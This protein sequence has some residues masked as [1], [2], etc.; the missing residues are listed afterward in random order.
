MPIELI[1]LNS[2][3]EGEIKKL[4]LLMGPA[5]HIGELSNQYREELQLLY[6]L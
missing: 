2:L 5:T 3:C 1:L 4:R 6:Q